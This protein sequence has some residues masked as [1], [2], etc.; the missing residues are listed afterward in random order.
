MPLKRRGPPRVRPAENRSGDTAHLPQPRE[1]RVLS[2]S[3][4]R[5]PL[6]R[7]CAAGV[8]CVLCVCCRLT[9]PTGPAVPAGCPAPR[10]P[11]PAAGVGQPPWP[12]RFRT[13]DRGGQEH[14]R[15]SHLFYSH[16][17]LCY[18]RLLIINVSKYSKMS[19]TCSLLME[20]K[21]NSKHC[22][23]TTAISNIIYFISNTETSVCLSS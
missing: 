13:A 10:C 4:P 5:P 16:Q 14:Q 21:Y 9:G 6:R 15:K 17:S 23:T 1:E 18:A 19:R 8:C 22:G 12:R 2:Q 7:R 3:P 20:M 11:G